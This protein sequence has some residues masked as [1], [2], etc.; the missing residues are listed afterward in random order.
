MA[1][2]ARHMSEIDRVATVVKAVGEPTRLR[3][4]SLLS[5]GELTVSEIVQVLG[6]SQPRVSRH[7]KLLSEAGVVERLPEG[8]WVFYRLADSN[9][10]LR[11]A[12]DA[13]VDLIPLEDPAASRDME[14]LELVRQ[15]RAEAARA[16][17]GS[18]AKDW[19]RIR[20]LHLA[21]PEVE[22]AMR[23]AAGEGPFELMIDVGT[24][25]GRALA[26]FA[27]RITRGVGIDSSHDMLTVAR[28]NLSKP[29]L[30]HCSVRHADLYALPFPNACADLVVIHLVLHYLDDPG[31]AVFEA[32]RT[33][34]S[35]GRLLVVDFAPHGHEF[36]RQGHA[37]RRLGF[38]D[39]EL[40]E[41]TGAAG[42]ES[43][44]P[45]A[46]APHA[47]AGTREEG[48]TVK[49]WAA[50]QTAAAAKRAG[51]VKAR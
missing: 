45:V 25:T 35:G 32:A 13:A 15:T 22:S 27:D 42:L 30:E 50:R 20:S 28:H 37:H 26:L 31:L 11:R 3:I 21:E 19:D 33:L 18:V 46:L 34:K 47:R 38:T 36:L 7:L 49:I 41:W 12:V 4:L 16:Y 44:A 10:A 43:D 1:L 17:F 5:R 23:A 6:Q 40:A 39:V 24:G 14:R 9:R 8:A 29:G 2:Y 51:K 48:L